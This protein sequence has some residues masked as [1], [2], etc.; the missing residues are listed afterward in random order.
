MSLPVLTAVADPAWE[1]GL[2]TELGSDD[3]VRVVRRCVDL[4]D[5]LSAATAGVGRVVIL[6]GRLRRL[7]REALSRL[8]AA[9]VAVVG[10]V[11]A[12]DSDGEERLRRLGVAHIVAPGAARAEISAAVRAAVEGL[13]APVDPASSYGWSG[14][15][16]SVEAE[17]PHRDVTAEVTARTGT[18]R[19]VAVWG[20]TGAPGRSTIAVNLAAEL[21]ALGR[22]SLLV[23]ADSYGGSAAVLLGILDEASG[24]VAACRAAN[25]GRLDVPGLA[26]LALE[27]RP[28]MRVLTGITRAERWLELRPSSLDVVL[29]RA[30]GLADVTVVDCGFCLEQDEELAYDT[31]AP[32]RNGATLATLASADDV[33]AV[34]AADPV[35]LT[36]YVRGYPQLSALRAGRPAV[37]VINRYRRTITGPRDPRGAV[38]EALAR[39]AGIV[40]PH[41]VP[42]DAASLDSAVGAGRALIEVA[43]GS[44]ARQA[45]QALARRLAGE[46]PAPALSLRRAPRLMIRRVAQRRTVSP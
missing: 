10:L 30:R 26:S 37:T 11:A 28:G 19:I 16:A 21:A 14:T 24:L 6:S 23:D 43:P 25:Q 39:F 18:G 17:S 35:G 2:V 3:A 5:L 9:G 42:D 1:S 40:D 22:T 12:D 15:A 13:A 46:A 32:R 45:I 31:T 44:A 29:D 41:W 36:R 34:G 33:V 7:D 20:P 4:A 27:V 8:A 38:G